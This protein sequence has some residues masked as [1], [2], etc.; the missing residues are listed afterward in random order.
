MYAK[1][2]NNLLWDE[3]F[4]QATEDVSTYLWALE[5]WDEPSDGYDHEYLLSLVLRHRARSRSALNLMV[6][7]TPQEYQQYRD[8]LDSVMAKA[9][10]ILNEQFIKEHSEQIDLIIADRSVSLLNELENTLHSVRNTVRQGNLFDQSDWLE[11]ELREAASD[12]LILFQ[13]MALISEQLGETPFREMID[14]MTFREKFAEIE[15]RF[16]EYFG[17]FH[18]ISNMFKALKEREYSIDRWWLTCLPDPDDIKH[19][20]IPEEL[21]E[22]LSKTFR[23]AG[24]SKPP[25][26]PESG[27][28]IAYALYEL[29]PEETRKLREHV[30]SCRYCLE[31]VMDVRSADAESRSHEGEILDV[32]PG[33]YEAMQPSSGEDTEPK[34]RDMPA[35]ILQQLPEAAKLYVK[36]GEDTE[37]KWRDM[38]A[39][40]LQQLPEAAKLYV[41]SGEDTEPKWRDMPAEILQQ[42]KQLP[43]AAQRYVNKFHRSLTSFFCNLQPAMAAATM[44]SKAASTETDPSPKMTFVPM[45]FP[46]EGGRFT[47]FK[48]DPEEQ[49]CVEKLRRYVLSKRQWKFIAFFEGNEGTT[50]PHSKNP[51]SILRNKKIRIQIPPGTKI[52]FMAFGPGDELEALQ[53]EFDPK[54][55]KSTDKK[56]YNLYRVIYYDPHE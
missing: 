29:D 23:E 13:D 53:N 24:A 26:C 22:S 48:L 35:G 36:S 8:K 6:R 44:S 1:T 42:L 15:G 45:T 25:D 40:I 9:E 16:K 34:W 38:P 18:T 2:D 33:L 39:G 19:P 11:Y 49:E 17:Y 32:L 50:I 4:E 51:E 31:L 37:P 12:F 47:F 56:E 46:D 3:I 14:S 55:M 30:L 52:A 43:E 10:R 21:M 54:S 20:E 27:K 5:E 7:D 41:K 28:A